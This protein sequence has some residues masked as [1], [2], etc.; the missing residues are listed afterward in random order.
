M[1]K[2]VKILKAFG[3]KNRLR[4]IKM[5]Q[6]RQLCV[7]EITEILGLA[8][9]TVSKH[10]SVLRDAGIVNDLK[11]GKWAIYHLNHSAKN[12]YISS[13]MPLISFWLKNDHQIK[14]DIEK[15][16]NSNSRYP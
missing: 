13:L 10:L 14:L 12:L 15:A 16:K 11:D 4:I 1:D 9:S 5:L 3:D 8:T 6:N 7:G 2:L